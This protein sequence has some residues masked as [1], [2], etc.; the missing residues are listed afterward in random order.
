MVYVN[1]N[2]S[3]FEIK[4]ILKKNSLNEILTS[5]NK[6]EYTINFIIAICYIILITNKYCPIIA[7]IC[8]NNLIKNK[9]INGRGFYPR[10]NYD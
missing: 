6:L 1:C 2:C 9:M 8:T 3:R 10:S 4:L 5:P 7:D